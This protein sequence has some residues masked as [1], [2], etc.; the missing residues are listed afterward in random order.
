M[1]HFSPID[2]EGHV[3]VP[4]RLVNGGLYTGETFK[5]G[6]AWGNT[7]IEPDAHVYMRTYNAM[8]EAARGHMP[9]YTRLGNNYQPM[10]EHRVFDSSKYANLSCTMFHSN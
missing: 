4:E 6:A 9:G 3:P 8:P 1:L 7:P 10:P 2:W 5:E